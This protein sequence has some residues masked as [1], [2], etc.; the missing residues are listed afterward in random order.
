MSAASKPD[1][2]LRC[3]TFLPNGR[4]RN[5]VA[6]QVPHP[7]HRVPKSLCR[8]HAIKECNEILAANER[9]VWAL[10]FSKPWAED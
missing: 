7:A 8:T 6:F 5:K 4:C 2:E 9:L 1:P 3:E 10:H